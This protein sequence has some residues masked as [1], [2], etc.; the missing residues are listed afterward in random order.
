VPDARRLLILSSTF[1]PDP[2]VAAI[3]MTQF[4]RRL[5]AHGWHVRVLCRHYGYEAT[6]L[7]PGV[8]VRYLS[9]PPAEQAGGVVDP[10]FTLKARLKA[11]LGQ[12]FVPDPSVRFWR[13]ASPKVLA[14]VDDFQPDA[15]L[16][17]SPPVAV[18][19]MGATLQKHRRL[20]WVVDLREAYLADYRYRPN[21]PAKLRWPAHAAFERMLYER[22][23]LI[24]HQLPVHH[25][26]ARR[27][28][29]AAF[30]K[31]RE[32]INGFAPELVDGSIAPIA[33]PRRS[34]RLIGTVTNEQLL[35][36]V[37]AVEW[38]VARGHDVE[39]CYVGRKPGNATKL[40]EMLG[41]RLTLTGFVPHEQAM[42]YLLGAD[43][44]VNYIEPTRQRGAILSTK[45]VEYLATGKPVVEINPTASDRIFARRWPQVRLLLDR[46][47]EGVAAALAEA[48]P[49]PDP[50]MLAAYRARYEWSHQVSQLAAWLDEL[51]QRSAGK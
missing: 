51:V 30:A 10:R 36:L 8:E 31:C 45:L 25:R 21:G 6:D 23:D 4:A 13:A 22:G 49:R 9:P 19:A 14:E 5:P 41:D 24:L 28:Y 44:L 46:G 42:A 27:K 18:H 40:T 2:M 1:Y 15:V 3:R 11:L 37:Q 29:P 16:T 33:S 20:P 34:I 50:A 12:A 35:R 47:T 32:L 43:L 38:L 7:P 26:W 17:T 48:L 39:L